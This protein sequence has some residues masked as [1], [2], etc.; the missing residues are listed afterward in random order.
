MLRLTAIEFILRT[1]PESFVFI[2]AAYLISSTR[3]N[4]KRYL[5]SSIVFAIGT[6]IIRMLPINYGVHTILAII[7]E[8]I[9]LSTI[10]KINVI[11]AVKSTIITIICLL[12][13]EGINMAVLFFIFKDELESIFSNPILKTLYGL[14]SLICFLIGILLFY[15]IKKDKVKYV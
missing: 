5:V 4:S 15:S 12:V 13:L 6:L 10:N 2:L 7:V 3:I 1:I 11:Q 14:P 8:T 9:I